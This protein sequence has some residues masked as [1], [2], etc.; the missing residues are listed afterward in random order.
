MRKKSRL[1]STLFLALMCC[2]TGKLQASGAIPIPEK[3]EAPQQVRKLTGTVEDAAGPVAGASISIKGT[4]RGTISD[5]NGAFSLDVEW[6]QTVVVS[7]IGYLTQE[8]AVREQQ[9]SLR[10]TLVEDTQALDE[11]VVTALGMKR[12]EKS[13]GYAMKEIGGGALN[14]NLIN[15]VSA[16]QGKVAGVEIAGSDGGMFGSA[17]ILIRGVSTLGKNNQP[18]YVVDGVILDN[19]IKQGDPDW[20]GQAHDFGNELKNLNPDDFESVSVLKGAAATA[21]YGSR[22]LNGAVVITTKNGRS[23]QGLGIEVSQTFGMDV[24]TATPDFQNEFGNGAFA[25]NVNYGEKNESGNYYTYDN[26]R[27]FYYNGDGR[28]SLI[29]ASS[30]NFGPAFDGREIEYYDGAYRSYRPVKN[31]FRQ[32]FNQGFNTNTNVAITGG[33][34]R[35]TF[36]TSLSFKHATGILPNNAFQRL[37]FLGKASHRITDRARIDVGMAFANSTPENPLR[38][39]GEKFV[40]ATWG[41]MYDPLLKKKYMGMHGGLA[42]NSYG[43]A[44]GNI[45]GRD[46]WFEIYENEDIQKETSVRPTVKLEI[47]LLDWLKF[48]TEA[49][50]NYYY[51]RREVKEKGQGY[52]G[53]GGRYEMNLKTKEQTNLN[54]NFMVNKS[55]GHWAFSGFLRGE[56]YNNFQ[57]RQDM[58]TEGG[59]IV[60]NQFFIKNS[61]NTPTY[62]AKL[63]GTKRILS[64]AFQAGASWRDQVFVDVTG[65][66]DWSSSLVYSDRHGTYSFFYPSVS[67][68]WLLTNTFREQLPA[69]ISFAK[70]RGSWAQVG[71]DTDPYIIN[72]AYD[73]NTSNASSGSSYYGL[74]L[75]VS[76]YD[77]NLKPERKNAWEIGADWRF[78]ENRFGVDVTYYKENTKNQIMRIAVPYQSGITEQLINA[79]NIQNRGVEVAVNLIPVKTKDLEWSVDLTYTKNNNKIVSLHENVADFI[80]LEGDQAYGNYRIASVAKVGSSFGTLMSDSYYKI[81]P[82]SGLPA[83]VWVDDAKRSHYLRN[84]AEIVEIGSSVPDFLGS[85]STGLRYKNWLLNV[86]LDMR[87]GGYVASYNSRYGTAYGF[88]KKSMEGAPG[89]GGLTWTS[90]YDGLTY[91]DGVI[92]EGI[93]PSGTAI[94]QADATYYTV[95][96]GGVS[97]AG[98]SYQELINKG[99]IEPTHAGA[100]NYRNNAWTMAGRD[101]GVISDSWVKKLNYI[102][103]RDV[104]ISYIMPQTICRKVSAKNMTLTLAGHNLGYLLNTMPSGENPE[105]V[106]GTAAAEFRSRSYQGVTSNFTFNVSLGF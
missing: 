29:G 96:A 76:T 95:S 69:W 46:V 37:S 25:P 5:M 103:L 82:S 70:V 6:G 75:P 61:K 50:Y 83:L 7:F 56:Y 45:P 35:T 104:S 57:Q 43:D 4:A 92:P 53:E 10:I 102:A 13:L 105:S 22:G 89:H 98:E 20:S 101:Y 79:G 47:D 26:Y 90:K 18:I 93:I 85:F 51:T 86:S 106:S 63:E 87:F 11:V 77:A 12:S 33:N 48:S 21:L 78:V 1:I 74:K 91:H 59:L 94:K 52:A 80:R 54:A 8:F 3:V 71:N 23:G 81:D 17:K 2:T 14:A 39:I 55:V 9:V 32:A 65:R 99:V 40:D 68:A 100:W 49:N 64:V 19:A 88:T 97:S 62:T 66:N 31:N 42:Q 58:N 44:Y 27:Q 34:D 16:L 28:P 72:T 67:G 38:N 36:Y 73:L 30:Y 84:E 41:R 24:M 60:P 15:P